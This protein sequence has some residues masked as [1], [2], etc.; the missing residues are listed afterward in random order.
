M[1]PVEDLRELSHQVPAE[2]TPADVTQF[3]QEHRIDEPRTG[4]PAS[5]FGRMT[6]GRTC[7]TTTGTETRSDCNNSGGRLRP[8]WAA[9]RSLPSTQ[10]GA[11]TGLHRFL[12]LPTAA[13]EPASRSASSPTTPT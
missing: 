11:S 8:R 2:V 12:S 10:A 6:A 7:P 13:S 5:D 9:H 1:W 4:L 3:V